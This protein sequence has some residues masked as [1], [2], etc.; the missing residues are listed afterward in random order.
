MRRI[1]KFL[2]LLPILSGF[3]LIPLLTEAKKKYRS[4]QFLSLT[5]GLPQDK[6]LT[7]LPKKPQFKGDWKKCTKLSYDQATKTLRFNPKK[8]GTCT[9]AIR[10]SRGK[11]AYEFRLVVKKSN[12][13]V[14]AKEIKSLLSEIDG[15]DVKIINNQVIVDGQVILPKDLA[16]INAVVAQF[17]ENGAVSLV[18]MSPIAEK[19][20]AKFIEKDINN[21]EIFV[22]TVNGKFIL[23]G[24]ANDPAEKQRAEIIAKT[25]VPDAVV[26][27]GDDVKKQIKTIQRVI[28]LLKIKSTP[29]PEPGK[30]IQVVVH[31]VEL[32]KDYTRG[33]GFNWSPSIS[34]DT[35]VT[36]S[37]GSRSPGGIVSSLTATISNLLPKLNWAKA[38]GYARVLQSSSVIVQDKK[39]G[40]IQ[41]MT[42]IPYQTVDSN[43]QIKTDFESAGLKVDIT[44]SIMG[45]RSD[46]IQ[47]QIDFVIKSLL[48]ISQ[49]GPLVSDRN[50]TTQIMVRSGNSAVIGGLVSNST[51]TGYNKLPPGSSAN[52]L[53]T[54]MAS[55]SFQRDQSQFVV[56]VTPL[57]K[58]SASEGANRVKRKFRL[59]D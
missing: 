28:N 54:L 12:L 50:I 58:S 11:K 19:K 8:I 24:Q 56:F 16:R 37:S 10:N 35:N 34:D 31:F 26:Q 18:T 55:K 40:H 20:I 9:L 7:Y 5:V 21:P 15:I 6:A 42:R 1:F 39:K 36:F 4:R 30:I 44:P 27:P 45:S 29:P 33:F 59:L 32:K 13:A 49:Q 25:Y 51:S 57:I 22:R 43:G 14:A 48:G 47:L 41:S 52:P 17:K 3:I 46:S 53:F 38:H 23:E 2:Y